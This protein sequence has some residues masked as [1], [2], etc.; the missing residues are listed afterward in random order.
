MN[1][2]FFSLPPNKLS[3]KEEIESSDDERG[4]KS[5]ESTEQPKNLGE[6]IASVTRLINFCKIKGA[7]D[8]LISL[9]KLKGNVE[10]SLILKKNNAVQTQITDF[11]R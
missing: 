9:Y 4:E 11:F 7:T 2:K 10:N 6:A 3:N 5:E 1:L 8:S